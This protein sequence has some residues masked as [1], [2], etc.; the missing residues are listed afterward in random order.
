MDYKKHEF[1]KGHVL[2]ASELNEMDEGIAKAMSGAI[3]GHAERHSTGGQDPLTPEM[4]GAAPAGNYVKTINGNVP[5]GEG[6]VNVEGGDVNVDATLTIEGAAA[7]SA[8]VGNAVNELSGAINK[9]FLEVLQSRAP[10]EHAE[11]HG[12][13][14]AD[15]LTPEMI[16]AAP[17]DKYVKTI[18]GAEPDAAGNI[19]VEGGG[20]AVVDTTLSVA[21]A[22]AE[23][24]AVGQEF[25]KTNKTINTKVLEILQSRAPVQHASETEEYG[26]ADAELFGHVKTAE[27][28]KLLG[29]GDST[30]GQD[31]TLW[32]D[33]TGNLI[34]DAAAAQEYLRGI[35]PGMWGMTVYNHMLGMSME[36]LEN[37]IAVVENGLSKCVKTVNGEAP[38]EN[39]NVNVEVGSDVN[40]DTTLTVE[41]AAA[42]AKAVGDKFTETNQTINA[43]A[44]EILQSRAAAVHAAQ[45]G[46]GGTD[47]IT[48]DMI[49]AAPAGKYVKKVNGSEPDENGNVNVEVGSDVNVDTTLSVE[50]AAADAKAVGDK[51]TETNQT[52][53]AKALEI[54]Q[55]RAPVGHTHAMADVSGLP[56]LSTRVNTLENNALTDAD[57]AEII[58]DTLTAIGT[59]D[60][61]NATAAALAQ[62]KG[63]TTTLENKYGDV[64]N[65]V[66]TLETRADTLTK[67]IGWANEDIAYLQEEF[68]NLELMQ[69][70][71]ATLAPINCYLS[72]VD[73]RFLIGDR[74]HTIDSLILNQMPIVSVQKDTPTTH[75]FLFDYPVRKMPDIP[76]S[77]L[78]NPID[79][80]VPVYDYA[81][82]EVKST[83][84]TEQVNQYTVAY[85]HTFVDFGFEVELKF[86]VVSQP[87]SEEYEG[88]RV[89]VNYFNE[90]GVYYVDTCSQKFLMWTY[91][92]EGDDI[93]APNIRMLFAEPITIPAKNVMS[94]HIL[95]A[96]NGNQFKLTVGNDGTLSAAA[97][98]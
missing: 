89:L 30:K 32:Y 73:Y 68:D 75:N 1:Q 74:S 35:V 5:D 57:K 97:V 64:S 88:T 8:A 28:D 48:P 87:Y 2:K 14:G 66:T 22:A 70:K 16:G 45:H 4:I 13:G 79:F 9:K 84:T 69:I 6:N 94:T 71:N 11:R 41:G 63:R 81:V 36:N 7:D 61:E 60:P 10:A 58:T 3:I 59:A 91:S 50:G 51:F 72:P 18:N 43:K 98:D 78:E 85:V 15:Q 83:V 52:I 56:D 29:M 90:P 76:I 77:I 25:E 39:G 37:D 96:P 46:S 27:M 26:I 31:P 19:N 62:L 12:V 54:L 82:F 95:T 55:S 44:L 40:V 23:A 65:R 67:R 21:G 86:L 38:D 80:L 20:N 34:G 17:A 47:Q 49:G 42:D 53:N 92:I 33:N 93:V 24:R